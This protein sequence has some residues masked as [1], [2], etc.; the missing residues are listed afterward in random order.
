MDNTRLTRVLLILLII[1]AALVLAQMLWQLLS[2]FADQLLLFLLGWL[3]AFVLNPVVLVVSAHP[4]PHR[5]AHA[6]GP[7]LGTERTRRLE[8][9]GVSRGVAVVTTYLALFLGLVL[10]V[11]ILA[12]TAVVQLSLLAKQM[13]DHI[14]QAPVAGVWAQDQLARFGVQLNVKDAL[15][16]GLAGLQ[17]VA[18]ELIQNTLGIFTSVLGLFA[19]LFFVLIIGFIITLDGPRLLLGIMRVV[20]SS[21]KNDI[22]FLGQSI[23]RTFGGFIRGQLI[24]ALLLSI[25]TAVVMSLFGVDFVLIA[26]L[27]AGLFMLIPLVG[28]FLAL[29][30]PLL[31]VLLQSPGVAIWVLLI[32]LIFQLGITNLLMPRLMSEAVGLHPLLVFAA[33]VFSIKIAGFWGAFF[34]IPVVGVLWAMAK[35]LIVEWSGS[36]VPASSPLTEGEIK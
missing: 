8:T 30:P 32:L 23:E 22:Q 34:G 26:S 31:V 28:P 20:P 14:A 36:G 15:S 13:P 17:S 6:F 21:F 9:W 5:L 33:I 2:G 24:Q 35:F 11:A 12:P 3:V 10:L 25:G 19:S 1:L 4:I 27:F 29:L 16:A 18:A 7:V